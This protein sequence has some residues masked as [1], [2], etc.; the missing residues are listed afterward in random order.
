MLV[1]ILV[2]EVIILVA[3]PLVYQCRNYGKVRKIREEVLSLN[4]IA[5]LYQES[6]LKPYLNEVYY[7]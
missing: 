5:V 3:L 7:S 2:I 1:V 4:S 6:T